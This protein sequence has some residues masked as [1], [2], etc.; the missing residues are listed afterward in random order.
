MDFWVAGVVCFLY[1]GRDVCSSKFIFQA[2]G[3]RHRSCMP[4]KNSDV[5]STAGAVQ[6]FG[7]RQGRTELKQILAEA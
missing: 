7:P 1:G 5:S 6:L 3:L 2:L 4:R